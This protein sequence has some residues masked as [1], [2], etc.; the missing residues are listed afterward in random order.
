MHLD[1][2]FDW[3]NLVT[4][5]VALDGTAH[6]KAGQR[7]AYFEEALARVRRIPGVRSASATEFLPIY[8]AAALG[9]RFKLDGRL[10]AHYSMIVPVFADYFETMRGRILYG[11]EFT[12]AEIRSGAAVAIV[13][14][15]FAA[16]FGSPAQA[17]GREISEGLDSNRKI[18]GVAKGMAYMADGGN[19][20]DQIFIPSDAPGDFYS[21][22][23]ARVDGRADNQLAMIRAAIQ[24]VDPQVPVFGV[25]TMEQRVTDALARPQFYRTA[26]VAFAAFALLLVVIGIYGIVSHTV[27]RRAHEMG[28]R[29]ALGTTPSL[30]RASLLRQQL[31]TIAAGAIPGIA[32]VFLSGRLLENLISGARSLNFA[33]YAGCV[34]FIAATGAIGIWVAS[35]PIA[36]IEVIEVL[37]NE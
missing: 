22:F 35:R 28:I 21:T 23:V 12:D 16:Q 10:A 34:L 27:S 26:V 9:D 17:V 3:S 36:R 13:D 1:R 25:K 4:V 11:R 14:E 30:L 19:G 5:N 24:S 18:V 31:I 8:S 33:A 15:R 6:E 37:R 32:G 29:M 2:G 20:Q 7:L